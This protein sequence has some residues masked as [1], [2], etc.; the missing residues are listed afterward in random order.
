MEFNRK[1]MKSLMALIA[2]AIILSAGIWHLS[3]VSQALG[4]L[5]RVLSFF[6][7]GLCLAFIINTLLTFIETRLF[8]PLDRR[9]SKRRHWP[10][11]RRVLSLI[12]SLLLVLGL[13][14]ALVFMIIPELGRTIQIIIDQFPTFVTQMEA[15]LGEVLQGANSSLLPETLSLPEIDWESIGAT[16]LEWLQTGAGSLVAGTFSAATSFAGSVVNFFVGI[17]VAIYILY[18]KEKLAAQTRRVLYAYLPMARADGFLSL[19]RRASLCFGNFITGQLLEAFILGLLCFLGMTILRFPFALMISLL[20]GVTALVPIFGAFIGF[21][22]G[23]VLI[24]VNQSFLQAVWFG[25]FFIVLQ[26]VEGNLIYPQVVG[27]RVMLPGLWVLT[28]VTV[29]GN[30]G[31]VLGMLLSVPLASLLYSLLRDAADKRNTEKKTP[32]EKLTIPNTNS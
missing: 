8:P 13:L 24:T 7:V 32:A 4:F 16:A 11:I 26:Q 10:Q 25:V 14:F 21:F 27:K 20:V 17:V 19:C 5:L 28:A 31:G 30:V 3:D 2:F 1:T 15:W 22:V 9:L 12:L 18:Q 6:L 23:F 29:G